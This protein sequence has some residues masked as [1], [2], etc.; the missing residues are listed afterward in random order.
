[1]GVTD[2]LK[3]LDGSVTPPQSDGNNNDGELRK[4]QLSLLVSGDLGRMVDLGSISSSD[5]PAKMNAIYMGYFDSPSEDLKNASAFALGRAAVG[6]TQS[7]FL[8]AIVN[9]LEENDNEK[10][11]YLLLS[12]LRGFIQSSYAQSGG[13]GIASNLPFDFTALDQSRVGRKGGC[14]IDG[15]RMLGFA[16][17]YATVIDVRKIMSIGRRSFRHYRFR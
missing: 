6:D 5:V 2:F 13:D 14:T 8:P 16:N 3:T 10:K 12:A 4:V 17:V 1:M 15:R 7:V 9:S 11:Q